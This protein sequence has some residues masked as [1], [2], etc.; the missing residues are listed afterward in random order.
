MTEITQGQA[1]ALWR[2]LTTLVQAFRIN[3]EKTGAWGAA[4]KVSPYNCRTYERHIDEAN[5]LLLATSPLAYERTTVDYDLL[6]QRAPQGLTE[7]K[8][9]EITQAQARALRGHLA[10]LADVIKFD[11][12]YN[13]AWEAAKTAAPRDCEAFESQINEATRLLAEVPFTPNKP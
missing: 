6:E 9:P 10:G 3:L 8:V 2:Q 13:D 7:K 5:K 1:L 4:K 11:L 12:K